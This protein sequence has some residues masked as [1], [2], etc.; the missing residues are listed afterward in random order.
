MFEITRP[1]GCFI[2][3][4]IGGDTLYELRTSLQLAEAERLNGISPHVS[5]MV[6]PHDMGG[7]L[8]SAGYS[9]LTADLDEIV[10]NY[11]SI[12]TAD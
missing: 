12:C 8:G 3:S 9:L 5:P 2:G 6:R 7:L 10:V 11:P 4:I 1:N